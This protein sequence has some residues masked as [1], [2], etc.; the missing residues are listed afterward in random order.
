VAAVIGHTGAVGVTVAGIYGSVTIQA[1][2]SYV[3]NLNNADPD[4]EALAQA[5]PPPRFSN[6]QLATS[7][8]PN[9]AQTSPSAPVTRHQ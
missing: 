3:Y 1:D 2:G 9:H 5:R 7:T 8:A 4:T 6:T